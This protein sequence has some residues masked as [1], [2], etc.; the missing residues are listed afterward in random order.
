[1]ACD[2]SSEYSKLSDEIKS[3]A[4]KVFNECK[5]A[6]RK[7]K[8][9][10]RLSQCIKAGDARN[11]GGGCAHI[12]GNPSR[13]YIELNIDDEFCEVLNPNS[14]EIESHINYYAK[15]RGIKKCI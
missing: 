8:Y 4:S 12:S 10:Y 7:S 14:K 9:L 11:I 6:V 1:M 15:K 3:D 5:D 2:P 13:K